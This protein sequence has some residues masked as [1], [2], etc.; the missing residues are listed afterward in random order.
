MIDNN[1]ASG[2]TDAE[3]QEM[4]E[5]FISRPTRRTAAEILRDND[6]SGQWLVEGLI[7]D[8]MTLIYGMPKA[9]K[10]ALAVNIAAALSKGQPV[11]GIT[12]STG[13]KPLN[14]AVIGSEM[15][16]ESE[17]AE[18]LSA[19]DADLD[20]I[21][22]EYVGASGEISSDTLVRARYG[23][24]DL[25]IIDNFQGFTDGGDNVDAATVNTVQR[26]L[27]P[28][29]DAGV[30]VVLIH[31]ASSWSGKG[32]NSRPQG[33]TQIEAMA[34][35]LVEVSRT[36]ASNVSI[37]A[38]GNI[39]SRREFAATVGENLSISFGESDAP[40]PVKT[41]PK[42]SAVTMDRRAKVWAMAPTIQESTV[43]G[44]AREIETRT[45]YAMNTVRGDL[46]KG[47]N[48][49]KLAKAEGQTPLYRA[50]EG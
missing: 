31:Q 32:K 43:S 42:R 45:G 16:L 4:F 1:N 7:C 20:R 15:N 49:G 25:A 29:V 17:Y 38:R 33:N 26:K 21:G 19:L 23:A 34:R 47:V 36:N 13:S 30:P 22:I 39:G 6:G 40:E 41:A 46:S 27:Q 48:A 9:G 3:A 12:P 5:E 37:V 8:S 10:S 2:Y 14:I 50:A 18:R 44:V 24:I 28:L 35:W 11:F